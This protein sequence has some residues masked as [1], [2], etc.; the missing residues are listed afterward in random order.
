M[1]CSNFVAV[2][3][4]VVDD[5]NHH[6]FAILEVDDLYPKITKIISYL[7]NIPKKTSYK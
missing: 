7:L 1:H 3:A 6:S 4:V 5:D 2:V